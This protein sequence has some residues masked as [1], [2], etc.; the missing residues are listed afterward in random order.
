MSRY[1]IMLGAAL[2][3]ACS[4]TTTPS[5][6]N[7]TGGQL[8]VVNGATSAGSAVKVYVDGQAVGGNVTLGTASSVLDVSTGLHAVQIRSATG[9]LG[10]ARNIQ[11]A[12]GKPV[13]AVAVDSE[14]GVMAAILDDTNAV[15][16]AGATK[17][18]VAHMAENAQVDI[19][20][21]QPDYQTPIRVMFPFV[22]RNVSPYLQSTPGEWR[23]MVS[24]PVRLAN[25]PM[26]DTLANSGL[27]TVPAGASRTVLLL[28]KPGGGIS[29]IVIEP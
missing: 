10:F 19:W 9:G 4:S 8:R 15:V 17:L 23:V 18:R 3:T 28:D 22:Y 16:P 25:D 27:I 14:G 1:M 11:F 26:P 21:T 12:A 20:R 2:A 24:S 5:D 6:G 29:L 13:T 7:G